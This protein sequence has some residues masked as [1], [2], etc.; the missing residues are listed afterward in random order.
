MTLTLALRLISHLVRPRGP[1]LPPIQLTKSTFL[2]RL[3]Y[4]QKIKI[5]IPISP[6]HYRGLTLAADH[7]LSLAPFRILA[8]HVSL[9]L[10]IA[11]RRATGMSAAQPRIRL[12][13]SRFP[14]QSHQPNPHE[15][16]IRWIFEIFVVGTPFR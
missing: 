11:D 5:P 8:F 12:Q 10:E 7:T 14:G 15:P 13:T 16:Q 4:P 2:A 9:W 1:K 3:T 6:I